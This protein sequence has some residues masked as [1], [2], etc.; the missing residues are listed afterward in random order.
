MEIHRG[1]VTGTLP[2]EQGWSRS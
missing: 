1:Q 2:P